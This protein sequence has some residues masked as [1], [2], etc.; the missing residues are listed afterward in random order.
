MKHF[1]YEAPAS[2]AEAEAILRNENAMLSAGGS[3]LVGVLKEKLLP[4]YPDKVV[5]LKDISELRGIDVKEDGLHIGAMTTLSDIAE[6]ATVREGW[7]AL[8]DAAYSVATPN[9]R[10]TATIGGNICQDV[11][12]WY[13]RYPDSIGGRINCARKEG[14]LCYAAMGETVITPSSA[15]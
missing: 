6:S 11:R 1:V 10:H 12:C 13:Y 14:H 7:N 2:V 4:S 5:S 15:L 8:A 9:I 3:D